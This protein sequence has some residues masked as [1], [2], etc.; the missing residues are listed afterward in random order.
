MLWQC[1]CSTFS[2]NSILEGG[3]QGGGTSGD[4]TAHWE[5]TQALAM[6]ETLTSSRGP[7][8]RLVAASG[9][10]PRPRCRLTS[11]NSPASC[12]LW[13][14]AHLHISQPPTK[15]ST[16]PLAALGR[17]VKSPHYRRLL[18]SA[19]S[20]PLQSFN[21]PRRLLIGLQLKCPT[22]AEQYRRVESHQ[23][24]MAADQQVTF[25]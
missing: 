21:V 23:L 2:E 4:Q 3:G 25:R 7:R 6:A 20:C 11:P 1:R 15:L 18:S 19:N 13:H 16:F 10:R 14:S 22:D 24:V 17:E 8:P 5:C 12:S 9:V